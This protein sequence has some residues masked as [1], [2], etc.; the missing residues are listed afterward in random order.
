MELYNNVP[1]TCSNLM[2]LCT[3]AKE[4]LELKLEL[5]LNCEDLNV[6]KLF[7]MFNL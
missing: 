1:K 2:H 7:Q 5:N 4:D 6:P 3:H